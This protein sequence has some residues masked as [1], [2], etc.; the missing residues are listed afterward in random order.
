MSFSFE[1]GKENNGFRGEEALKMIESL[2]ESL[3]AA[4]RTDPSASD[5]IPS[6]GQIDT[7]FSISHGGQSDSDADVVFSDEEE[8]LKRQRWRKSTPE[9]AR[10]SQRHKDE[11]EAPSSSLSKLE[12]QSGGDDEDEDYFVSPG[13]I[14]LS[15]E[16]TQE[17]VEDD[18]QLVKNM[19][20]MAATHDFLRLFRL[21]LKLSRDVGPDELERVIVTSAGDGGLLAS[22]HTD[23]MRGTSPKNPITAEN[24]ITHLANKIKHHWKTPYSGQACPFKPDKYYEAVTYSR[25]PSV[26]RVRALHFLC[27]LRS[28]RP[29]IAGR[30]SDSERPKTKRELAAAKRGS[31]TDCDDGDGE[32]SLPEEIDTFRLSPIGVDS[33]CQSYYFFDC[34]DSTGFRFYRESPIGRVPSIPSGDLDENWYCKHK[35]QKYVVPDHPLPGVWDLVATSVDE[36]DSVAARLNRS[37]KGADKELARK[38]LNEI[39][40]GIQERQEAE[41]RRLRAAQRVQRRLG[42]ETGVLDEGARS[43]RGRRQVNYAFTE[44]DDMLRSAIRRSQRIRDESPERRRRAYSPTKYDP[45]D[46]ALQGLRRGRSAA[47][48]NANE[49][50]VELDER[51]LRL[52]RGQ[53]GLHGSAEQN[54]TST[55][56]YT[57]TM[58]ESLDGKDNLNKVSPLDEVSSPAGLLLPMA[59]NIQEQS[60]ELPE[61]TEL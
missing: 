6:A 57:T 22:L 17:E 18:L 12:H 45:I 11:A 42:V 25:L 15:R 16:L 30:I 31:R 29:D 46:E 54:E 32:E 55:A 27:C 43:R 2:E 36:L 10:R 49:A 58:N 23:L 53:R 52:Q 61:P 41:E 39:L 38:I 8:L 5:D 34:H 9:G 35:R 4:E 60:E 14:V 20:E 26:D 19:W 3:P 56:Q 59:R 13:S 51:K 50:P 21:Q 37:M 7:D 48:L 40:P 1:L 28:D 47:V 24:W 33:S 44:Y